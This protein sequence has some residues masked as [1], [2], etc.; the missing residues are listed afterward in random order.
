MAG[1]LAVYVLL[2]SPLRDLIATTLGLHSRVCY[3]VCDDVV[4]VGPI[5]DAVS[6]WVLIVTAMLAGSTLTAWSGVASYERPLVFGLGTLACISGPS[7]TIAVIAG[8]TGTTLLRPPA[9]PLM[10]ALPAVAIVSMGAWH[11]RRLGQRRASLAPASRLVALVWGLAAALLMT[12]GALSVLHPPSG[13]DALGYHAPLGVFLWREGNASS[14]V[15]RSL[16]LAMPGTIQLWFGLLRI[17][18]GESLADLGQLPF[19][20]LG[21]AGIFAFTRRLGLGRGAGQLAAGAALLA[22]LVVTQ[23]G[24]QL[25]DVAGAGLLMAT[26]A[27]ASAPAEDWTGRRLAL[28]GLGLGLALTTKLALLPCVAAVMLFVVGALVR[29]PT[30]LARLAPA[31]LLF[32]AIAAPW[33]VRNAVRFGNPLY[34]AALPVLGRG[35]VLSDPDSA[36]DRE[37]VPRA[38]L[39]PLYPLFERY[40]DRS[41]LGALFLLGVVGGTATAVRRA[42]RRPLLIYATIAAVML[43]AWWMLTNHDPRFLLPVFGLGFAFLPYALL[44]VPRDRRSLGARVLAAGAV[45]SA[46]V[47]ADQVLLPLARQPTGRWEF[48]DQVWGLDSLV[49]TMPEREGML[50]H[51]GF[52]NYTYPTYY[53]LLGPS[54][55]RLVVPVDVDTPA[56]SI[57]ARMRRAGVRY[58]YVAALPK[59]RE[60]VESLYDPAH[61]EL[62]HVSTVDDGWRAGTRR[63]LFRLK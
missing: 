1:M 38:S 56:D 44:A 11:R 30:A 28:L 59:A 55:G 27:L 50:L 24:L 46:L 36:I 22:P 7:A 10:A 29:R 62:V 52:A 63:Y 33:G 40:S 58:A 39:W 35:A 19:A 42:R 54:F 26:V 8:W 61:F 60:L 57:V 23:A 2:H 3:F 48:Y 31:M 6:A 51:T 37:F 4:T 43:P 53:P 15:D 49:A 32:L 34:P 17:A 21:A 14:F 41:G 16:A 9:G 13:Y 12:S 47:T 5:L 25:A 18:G 45:F 20:L